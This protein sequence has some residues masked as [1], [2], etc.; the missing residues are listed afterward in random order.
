MSKRRPKSHSVVP[1]SQ[2]TQLNSQIITNCQES[3]NVPNSQA[4]ERD[5]WSAKGRETVAPPKARKLPLGVQKTKDTSKLEGGEFMGGN[6][7]ILYLIAVFVLAIFLKAM[8]E[9]AAP[10]CQC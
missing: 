8:S 3:P 1:D 5:P 9:K 6:N 4:N 10:P 7:W 2:E